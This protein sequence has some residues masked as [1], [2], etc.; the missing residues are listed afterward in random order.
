MKEIPLTRGKVALV[1]DEDYERVNVFKWQAAPSQ[2]GIWYAVRTVTVDGRRAPCRMH[3]FIMGVPVG[4]LVDHRNRD[5]LDCQRRNLRVAT[6]SQNGI[7]SP[8]RKCNSSGFKGVR[9]YPRSSRWDARI[10]YQ[11]RKIH[12]GYFDTPEQAARAYDQKAAELFGEFAYL[13]FA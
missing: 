3:R 7:N 11:G 13:N 2:S 4:V 8:K 10:G 12:I 5:G 9:F 1:D 6:G